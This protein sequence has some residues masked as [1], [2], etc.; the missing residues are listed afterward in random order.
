MTCSMTA[1]TRQQSEHDWGTLV[2]EIRSVNHR[3]L[4]PG[5]RLP[6][7]LRKLEAN[8]REMLRNSVSRGKIDAQ[9]KFTPAVNASTPI[10]LNLDLLQKLNQ[11]NREIQ[12]MVDNPAPVNTLDLLRYPGIIQ[13]QEQDTKS[14]EEETLI[15]FQRSLDSLLEHRR[16]EGG[17]LAVLIR[18]RLDAIV[19]I[20][21]RI[22]LAMPD[23]LARQREKLKAQIS[24]LVLQADPDRLEQEIVLIAQKA[25]INE[26]VD[27]LDTHVR[28][29][30]RVLD[31]DGPTGRRLDFLMQELNREANTICSKAIVT[32]TTLSAVE[33]K[34]LIEQMREQIQNIE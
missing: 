27:R 25:D 7:S 33:L 8:L 32:Q 34:V 30:A 28:E 3:F 6:D 11:A 17:E 22:R 20:V 2:W 31:Q 12:S 1:F 23:I 10:Q 26:E 29:V 5:I 19:E 21:T 14:I 4:E 13:E 16:R 9:L 18:Q 15:L 24:E